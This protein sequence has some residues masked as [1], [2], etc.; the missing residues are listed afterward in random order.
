M[1]STRGYR[2]G[3]ASVPHWRRDGRQRG[4]G[5]AKLAAVFTLTISTLCPRAKSSAIKFVIVW[6]YPVPGGPSMTIR[7][8]YCDRTTPHP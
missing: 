8:P 3:R 1:A 2:S 7:P 4:A 5:R 6:L